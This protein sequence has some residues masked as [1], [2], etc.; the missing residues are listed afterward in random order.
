MTRFPAAQMQLA[1]HRVPQLRELGEDSRLRK[2]LKFL[3]LRGLI[4]NARTAVGLHQVTARDAAARGPIESVA[5][6]AAPLSRPAA[7]SVGA[8]LGSSRGASTRAA[9]RERR[10]GGEALDRNSCGH[11]FWF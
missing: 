4:N 7:S 9:N 1:L 10:R 6:V 3:E 2:R 8:M 5:G 11:F